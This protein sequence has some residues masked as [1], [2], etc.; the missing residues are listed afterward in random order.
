MQQL[1]VHLCELEALPEICDTDLIVAHIRE[2]QQRVVT[3]AVDLDLCL[4]N[5][6][7]KRLLDHALCSLELDGSG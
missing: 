5:V 2:S 7:L 3:L 1:L 4:L 6:A